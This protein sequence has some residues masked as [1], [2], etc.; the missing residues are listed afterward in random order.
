MRVAPLVQRRRAPVGVVLPDGAGVAGEWGTTGWDHV[1]ERARLYTLRKSDLWREVRAGRGRM[2]VWRGVKCTGFDYA[3][4]KVTN[5][6]GV[7][8]TTD[9]EDAL[10]ELSR[11]ADWMRE[12]GA[13]VGSLSG[14]AWS[15]WRSS[16]RSVATI[17][18]DEPEAGSFTTGG[19]QGETAAGIYT[20]VELWDLTAAYAHTLGTLPVPVDWR[21]WRHD[22]SDRVPNEGGYAR[23]AVRVPP[24]TWG[25]LPER[26]GKAVHYPTDDELDG[27][28]TF[29]EL[30]AALRIGAEVV[31]TDLWTAT[32]HRFLFRDWWRIVRQGRR[33][34]G[35][36]AGRLVK[37]SSNTLWGKF[38]TGGEAA[39]WSFPGAGPDPTID[40]EPQ[41]P[42]PKSPALAGLVSGRIRARLFSEA[43]S[44]AP[45]IACHTDGVI[46]PA[47]HHLSPNTGAPGRWRRADQASRLELLSA[48]SFRYTRPDG[49]T[50]YRVSGCSPSAAPGV[51]SRLLRPPERE[52]PTTPDDVSAWK[53][54]LADQWRAYK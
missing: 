15:L 7:L 16:L 2:R 46:M 50:V 34:L 6:R 18:G 12:A 1:P 51:F 19:R 28:F 35:G 22:L 17:Y 5:L 52:R 45:V 21:R 44:Q 38:L 53:A 14:T 4:H 41:R 39:W 48:Q 9:H 20:D 26:I 31:I 13:N 25:P 24:G 49:E 42:S 30:R 47:G 27:V 3:G 36:G 10:Y 32:S 40:P 23:A 33:D 43:L 54:T 11:W 8:D 37:A 29:D